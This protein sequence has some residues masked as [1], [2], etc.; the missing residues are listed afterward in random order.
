MEFDLRNNVGEDNLNKN[1]IDSIK[2]EID[3][4]IFLVNDYINYSKG[5][6]D[7]EE[8]IKRYYKFC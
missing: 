3:L 2:R 8:F 1:I 4:L 7:E 5:E 6:I